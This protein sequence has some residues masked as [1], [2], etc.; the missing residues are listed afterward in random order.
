MMP[1]TYVLAPGLIVFGIEEGELDGL[2]S[3]NGGLPANEG[4]A[5]VANFHAARHAA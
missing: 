1:G 5:E 4:R 2:A 3:R